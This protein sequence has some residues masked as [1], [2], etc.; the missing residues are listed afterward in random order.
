MGDAVEHGEGGVHAVS[1][2]GIDDDSPRRVLGLYDG[3]VFVRA[4]GVSGIARAGTGAI[5]QRTGS[6]EEVVGRRS[7]GRKQEADEKNHCDQDRLWH[8]GRTDGKE[9]EE[10]GRLF[11]H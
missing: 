4:G 8:G 11:T 3:A 1:A 2:W 7:L 6:I 10:D 9:R 5:A